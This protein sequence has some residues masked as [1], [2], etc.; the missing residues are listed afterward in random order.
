MEAA[1]LPVC[2]VQ[3]DEANA[4][5]TTP[6][7]WERLSPRDALESRIGSGFDVHQL[8][9]DENRA[10]MLCGVEIPSPLALK[11][12]SDADVGLHALVDALLGALGKG[13]IGEH[14]PPS[15]AQWKNADSA[16]FVAEAMR[17]L[18]LQGA[19]LVN[20]DIT[21]IAETPKL[22]HHKAAMRRRVAQLLQTDE[23]R[24]NIKATTTEGLGFVGRAEG[25][26]AQAVISVKR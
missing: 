8:I 15:D 21:I 16:D 9:E 3:G 6:E 22:M 17:L 12:H 13:D 23:E 7:D 26:A 10:L 11:G 2:F 25:I 20:A 18:K 19:Q 4:K 1:G 14:F 24:I 5:L